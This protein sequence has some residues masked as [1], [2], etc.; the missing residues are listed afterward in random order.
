M[1]QSA[2]R[3]LR[4]KVTR[5]FAGDILLQFRPVP[6]SYELLPTSPRPQDTAKQGRLHPSALVLLLVLPLLVIS[7]GISAGLVLRSSA[8]VGERTLQ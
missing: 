7:V 1:L 8:S 3:R 5:L 2:L 4:R 6:S